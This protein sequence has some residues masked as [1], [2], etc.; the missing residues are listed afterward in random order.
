MTPVS[1]LRDLGLR[2]ATLDGGARREVVHLWKSGHFACA[3]ERVEELVPEPR[4]VPVAGAA[5]SAKGSP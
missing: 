2:Y 4:D 5:Q 3:V 1:S